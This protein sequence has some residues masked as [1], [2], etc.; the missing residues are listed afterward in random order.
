MRDAPWLFP[1]IAV[2]LIAAAYARVPLLGFV[3]DDD[4]IVKANPYI[5][6]F[7]YIPT[8]F[9]E[10]VWTKLMFARNNYYRPVF[11][12]WLLGNYKE[13]GTD[14][15]GWH[16]TSLMLHLGSSVF[17]Y[18]LALRF[19]ASRFAALAAA[20]VFGLHPVQVENVA[21]TSAVT[22]L[23]CTFLALA[24]V[25]CYLRS[26]DPGKRRAP[27]LAASLFLYALSVM[28]KETAII[29]PAIIFLHEWLGRPGSAVHPPARSRGAAF[30][31][32]FR[33]SLPFGVVALAYLA[34]RVAV[35]GGLGT[36]VA[37][38]SM[39]VT[40]LTL[41]SVLQ[42]YMIHVLWPARLSV[43]YDFPYVSEFSMHSVLIPLAILACVALALGV[44]V[45]ASPAGR[46]SAA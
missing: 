28:A 19:T 45:R 18:L 39:R 33:E 32:A 10:H 14:P 25:L 36:K 30:A 5:T 20:L 9:T 3:F 6:S 8:Y 24:S 23:L 43:F 26:L 27:I 40:L 13:F 21:W 38:I 35:L 22:E 37:R 17:L 44:A 16:F 41:P 15:L 34:A 29:I 46:L 2:L 11:L 1:L 31:A 12:L 7:R 4:T 42:I